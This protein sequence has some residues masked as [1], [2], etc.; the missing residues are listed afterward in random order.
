MDAHI[1]TQS[2]NDKTYRCNLNNRSRTR[3]AAVFVYQTMAITHPPRSYK[4]EDKKSI[5]QDLK[6]S[7]TN[8]IAIAQMEE[9][10]TFDT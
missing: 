1:H 6:R 4:N 7:S 8:S 3:Y 9:S 2:S 10:C 5:A